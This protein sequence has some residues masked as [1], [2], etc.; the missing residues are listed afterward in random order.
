[1]IRRLAPKVNAESMA[2][3]AFLLLIFFLVSTTIETD[4]GISR[5]LPPLQDKPTDAIIKKNNLLRVAINQDNMLS[6][7][8][9]LVDFKNLKAIAIAF[10]DNG[11]ELNCDYCRGEKIKSSS[12]HPTKA[13]I[14]LVNTRETSYG[15]YIAVQNELIGAYRELRSRES[16]RLFGVS[17]DGLKKSLNEKMSKKEKNA[18]KERIKRIQL[19]YPEKLTEAESKS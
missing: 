1:M 10:L 17:F 11:G 9:E 19:M 2:D 13:V 8:D 16:M 7:D 3:I 15:A 18:V 14:S 5:K 4:S 6:V 12:D